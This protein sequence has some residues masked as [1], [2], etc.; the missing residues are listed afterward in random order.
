LAIIK[1]RYIVANFM[2]V[3]VNWGADPGATTRTFKVLTRERFMTQMIAAL[4]AGSSPH[5]VTKTS[6][7]PKITYCC[8]R[9]RNQVDGER[10]EHEISEEVGR[11]D[12]WNLGQG[13][14]N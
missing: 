12:T 9:R 4:T 10:P 8:L 3:S 14:L 1:R 13:A 6:V 11:L 2:Q 7:R 5:G